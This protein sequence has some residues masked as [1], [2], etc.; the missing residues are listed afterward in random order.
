MKLIFSKKTI[1]EAPKEFARVRLTEEKPG[2]KRLVKE[3]SVTWL[4]IGAAKGSEM[5]RRKFV[6]LCRYII[7][8]AKAE[9]LRKIV[10]QFDTT[11]ELF[12]NLH[13]ITPEEISRIAA[14]NFVMANLEF[15][16]YKEKPKEG[17][18]L[19]EE[20][21]LCG[22]SSPSIEAAAKKGQL[23][24]EEVNRARTL[25]NMPGGDMTPAVLAKAAQ[26]ALKG[27]KANVTILDEKKMSVLKMGAVLGVAKGAAEKPKFII[28]EYFNGPKN[29]KPVV[30]VGKGVTFDTGGLNLKGD[31]HMLGMHMD[32]S[33]GA[34]VIAALA[35]TAK[36]KLK[37]NIVGLIPAVENAISGSAYR[38]GDV[39]RGMSGKTIEILNTD[40][41]GRVILSDALTY[42]EKYKPRLVVDAATLTGAALVALGQRASGLFTKDEKLKQKFREL[43]EESGDY[44][45]P[46]PMWEEYEG[47]VKGNLAD[48]ANITTKG[49]SRYAGATSGAMFLY[50][51]AKNYPWVHLDIAPRMESIEEDL[52][53]KGAAGAPVRLFVRLLENY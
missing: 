21:V 33:G 51:F 13:N 1:D 10:L 23:I 43:G 11:P 50:H 5:N 8:S 3:G 6:T 25:S 7:R 31:D 16:E 49:N 29:E 2:T 12:T 9:K 19:I 46:L 41:E 47:D 42:A 14:E 39:L 4:E 40:A 22:K 36:L 20:L 26:D 34:A 28:I 45:W 38:P 35:A 32:M 44:V 30:L 48:V 52:L 24:G 17:W 27:T 37:K 15:N 53:A 18:N